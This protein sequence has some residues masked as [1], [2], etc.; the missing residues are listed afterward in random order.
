MLPCAFDERCRDKIAH[1]AEIAR[2]E[3]SDREPDLFEVL[4]YV[5]QLTTGISLYQWA[6]IYT[7]GS[8]FNQRHKALVSQSAQFAAQDAV[9]ENRVSVKKAVCVVH[10]Y[11]QLSTW[12]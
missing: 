2:R 11:D 9:Y 3:V 8:R 6:E 4:Q 12:L 7:V 1:S 10:R 5:S